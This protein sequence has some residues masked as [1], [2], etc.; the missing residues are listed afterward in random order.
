[1]FKNLDHKSKKPPT[2]HAEVEYNVVS[3]GSTNE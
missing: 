3:F 1:M 2:A